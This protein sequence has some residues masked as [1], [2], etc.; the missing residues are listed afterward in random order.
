MITLSSTQR[1]L[2]QYDNM[3][4][5]I[6]LAQKDTK[7]VADGAAGYVSSWIAKSSNRAPR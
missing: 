3:I 5:T 6:R 2:Q 7:L 4:L 1:Q